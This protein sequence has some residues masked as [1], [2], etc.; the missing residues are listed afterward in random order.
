MVAKRGVEVCHIEVGD[1]PYSIGEGHLGNYTRIPAALSQKIRADVDTIETA[2]II[3]IYMTAV[4]APEHVTGV[5]KGQKVLTESASGVL[6]LAAIQVPRV[7][8]AGIFV[9]DQEW[10]KTFESGSQRLD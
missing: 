9:A 8:G 6:E 7:K 1:H 3:L 4:Y 5:R 10:F 2:T